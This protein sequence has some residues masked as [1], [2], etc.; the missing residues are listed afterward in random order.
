[1]Y[2]ILFPLKFP[3]W[4]CSAYG[5]PFDVMAVSEV[6]LPQ[7]LRRFYCEAKPKEPKHRTN[8]LGQH[9]TTCNKN[10]M[11]TTRAAINRYLQDNGGNIDIIRGPAFKTANNTLDGLLKEQTRGGLS[12]PTLHKDIIEEEDFSKISDYMSSAAAN[13]IILRQSVWLN[14]AIHFVSRGL[15]FHHQLKRGTHSISNL[16][17]IPRNLLQ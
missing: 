14:L 4:H 7:I 8:A 16:M 11:N 15:E 17:K 1:M 5:T 13:P 9:A 12:R 2:T 6:D 3:E 10:T